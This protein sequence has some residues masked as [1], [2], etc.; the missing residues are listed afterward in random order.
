[1]LF[2][3]SKDYILRKDGVELISTVI[4]PRCSLREISW[5]ADPTTTCDTVSHGDLRQARIVSYSVSLSCGPITM[6]LRGY[7]HS[8]RQES[9]RAQLPAGIC[10]ADSFRVRPR[11]GKGVGEKERCTRNNR[12]ADRTDEWATTVKDIVR[13]IDGIV[14]CNVN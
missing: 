12:R 5:I 6:R 2:E 9:N 14:A 3:Y 4:L 11:K 7:Y 8:A 10:N 1:M 13:S